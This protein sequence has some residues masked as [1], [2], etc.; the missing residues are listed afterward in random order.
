MKFA[1]I[2]RRYSTYKVQTVDEKLFC[3]AVV[4]VFKNK[5]FYVKNLL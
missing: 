4:L 1:D 5:L 2:A 3:S